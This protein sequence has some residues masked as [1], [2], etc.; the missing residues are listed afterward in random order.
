MSKK[1]KHKKKHKKLKVNDPGFED[2]QII[3]EPTDV[4]KEVIEMDMR[5]FMKH[6]TMGEFVR[7]KID[8]EFPPE[9]LET[10]EEKT[11]RY[12]LVRRTFQNGQNIIL[13][14]PLTQKQFDIYHEH[15]RLEGARFEFHEEEK[16]NEASNE[17]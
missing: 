15:R 11:A 12:V 4:Q 13:R 10:D 3:Q 6:P 9:F 7:E 14:S 2:H 17:L 1:D 5:I 8:G 16:H